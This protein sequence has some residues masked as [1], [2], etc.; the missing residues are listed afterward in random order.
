MTFSILQPDPATYRLWHRFSMPTRDGSRDAIAVPSNVANKLNSAYTFLVSMIVLH[1]WVLIL[2]ALMSYYI[3]RRRRRGHPIEAWADI[4]NAKT[5]PLDIVKVSAITYRRQ[6]HQWSM[7]LWMILAFCILVANYAIP[8]EVAPYIILDNAAPVAADAIY[9]P[10][11]VVENP[12]TDLK[13]FYL[14]APSA[15]RAVGNAQTAITSKKDH[16]SVD[17][18]VLLQDLGDG[19]AIMRVDYRYDVSGVDFGLQHYPDLFLNVEGSCTTDYEMILPETESDGVK[20][21]TYV[22]W[23]GI[24]NYDTATSVSLFD[25]PMPQGFL[26]PGPPSPTGPPGN[27]TWAAIVSSLG[28]RSATEGTDPWYLT[29]PV[30]INGNQFYEVRSKRPALSCWQNDV[31]SYKGHNSTI[32]D[33]S[34]EALPGLNLPEGIQTILESS[35][36]EPRIVTMGL[37]LGPQALASTATSLGQFFDAN[38]SSFH[39]D[40]QRLVIASYVASANTLTE[41]TLFAEDHLGI[42][43]FILGNDGQILPGAANFVIWSSEVS[44]LSVRTLIIIPAITLA[45]FLIVL[46]VIEFW[47]PLGREL[48]GEPEG[49]ANSPK[50]S[51]NDPEDVEKGLADNSQERSN[52]AQ[53]R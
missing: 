42:Q 37:Q 41:S 34:P 49:T 3:R 1:V 53:G 22:P 27:F 23:P 21:D 46:Y 28:R 51:A 52:S 17:D 9:I 26:R 2:L 43:N 32:I 48:D 13:L 47:P 4:W 31:W 25:G 38:Q 40:V 5:S 45:L 18:P 7:I 11:P 6:R 16:V 35:L 14:Q 29:S 39:N 10:S 50:G 30:T 24:P 8:I 15:F 36:Y 33:L 44:T 12:T 20:V 19:E